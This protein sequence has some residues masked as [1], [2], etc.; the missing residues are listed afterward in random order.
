YDVPLGTAVSA[1][2]A[3]LAVPYYQTE[4]QQL[5]GL[6]GG[7]SGAASYEALLSNQDT[8]TD[9]TAARL[10]A[11]L[12]GALVLVLVLLIGNIIYL[13]QRGTRREG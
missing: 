9:T 2:V 13:A 7:V 1:S 5:I 10:D 6:L 12:A 11:Q 4:S 8:P 3:P